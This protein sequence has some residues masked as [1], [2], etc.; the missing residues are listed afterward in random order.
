MKTSIDKSHAI[1]E[2]NVERINYNDLSISAKLYTKL[3][4]LPPDRT[5]FAGSSST[6]PQSG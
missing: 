5:H 6:S 2:V 4:A 3:V 1:N